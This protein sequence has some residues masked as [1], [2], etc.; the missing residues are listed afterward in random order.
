MDFQPGMTFSH[1]RIIE[2][3]GAGG[4]GKVYRAHDTR[5]DRDVAIKV[6]RPAD[7]ADAK[8]RHRLVRE[9]RTASQLNHP[10]ICTIHEVGEADGLVYMAMEC[11]EGRPL[12]VLAKPVGLP[13][14]AM[15]RYGTQIAD[16]LA[17]AHEQGVVHRDLKLANVVVTADGRVK[18]L[19]FGIAT[20]VPTASHDETSE[21]PATLTEHGVIPGTLNYMAPEVLRGAA[22]DPRS[23][24]WSLGVMLYEMASGARPFRGATEMEVAAAILH[25]PAEPLPDRVP[26]SLAAVIERCLAKEPGQRYRQAGE[27][28]AALEAISSGAMASDR[29]PTQISVAHSSRQRA[30]MWAIPA[31]MLVL[32]LLV[33]GTRAMQKR[34]RSGAGYGRIQSL[35]VLPLSNFS[36]DPEQE[37]FVDG[38]TE[39]LIATLA[40]IEALRVISR[41]SVM[42]FRGTT[43]PLP[44]IA[45]KLGVDAIVEGSVQRS[46]DQVRITAQLIRA[47]NDEHIWAKSYQRD[48]RDVL[49]LQREVATAIANEVQVHLSPK[50]Q[51][52]IQTATAVSP[53]A[54]ELYLRGLESY[55]RFDERSDQAALEFLNRAIGVDST[56]APAWAA[57]GLVS[58]SQAESADRN[59]VAWVRA[60]RAV[61]RALELDPNLGLAHSV[62]AQMAMHGDW[63]WEAAER[64]YKRAIELT[65]SSFEA[66]HSYSHLLMNMGRIGASLEHSQ[67][68][69]ALDPL[70]AS[71]RVHMGWHYLHAGQLK[72]ALP[73]YQA[74]LQLDPS[75]APAYEQL[76]WVYL[77]ANRFDE[78]E[79]S[80]RKGIN[81]TGSSDTLALSA[82]I[83]A[84]RG[85][86]D[87]AL[88]MNA[89]LIDGVN[90][91][92]RGA[93]Q[94]ATV[95]ALLGKRDEAFQ[96]LDRA[97]KDREDAVL[98]LKQDPFLVTLRPDPR[99]PT[100]LRRIGL[101]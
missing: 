76:A 39:E 71:A 46:G 7:A 52:K 6:L 94:A 50:Q 101:G 11:V 56:Y 22:A 65:P 74:A 36:H 15:V 95:F 100:L 68:S 32:A 25:Q 87:S 88:R 83:A 17:Y 27:V 67:V 19:D 29:S 72:E 41:T 58:V 62:K 99:F 96:W 43:R 69:V 24:I 60:G 3:L 90:H 37:Y 20:R 73:E 66:H 92:K 89:T 91:G 45:R 35:A 42:G 49:T 10:H 78:A 4:M 64:E 21:L 34:F 5:L 55:R 53:E 57:V 75:Y 26:K 77:L 30:W 28:R 2:V 81:L 93:Y 80:R 79:A 16:A 40:Q 85:R 86:T 98:E 54:Y 14:D 44:E 31:A 51:Q 82:M 23:D 47:K 1:Y 61:A 48:L 38:M 70:S 13:M 84:K 63:N 59:D 97:I 12:D 33:L 18:V 8:A 9:A